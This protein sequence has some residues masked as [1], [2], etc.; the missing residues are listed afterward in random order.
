[1]RSVPSIPLR[2]LLVI[3]PLAALFLFLAPAS[4]A[5]PVETYCPTSWEVPAHT[6]NWTY[7]H[8]TEK[9]VVPDQAA[10]WAEWWQYYQDVRNARKALPDDQWQTWSA[11]V[12]ALRSRGVFD[13]IA[14][15]ARLCYLQKSGQFT[16]SEAYVLIQVFG[17][18]SG[19]EW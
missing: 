16:Y 11:L 9:L 13:Q 17:L 4:S 8:Y 1:M 19:G 14:D 10:P 7:P 5:S 3:I 6:G 18:S 12:L 15:S 2:W